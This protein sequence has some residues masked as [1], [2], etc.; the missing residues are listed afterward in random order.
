MKDNPDARAAG[1]RVVQEARGRRSR[2]ARA[3][4][5]VPRR[6]VGRVRG[7][8]RPARHRVR[9]GPRRERVRARHG[10]RDRGAA[11]RADHRE[12]GRAGRR[13]RGREDAD[14][15][16]RPRTAPRCTRRA[17]S[18]R[19]STAGR[20]TT[21]RARSTS[22]IAARRCTSASCSSCSRRPATTGPRAA[23]T[24]RTGWSA[25]GGKKTGTRARQRRAHAATCSTIAA[26]RG[27]RRRSPSATR[28]CP[29]SVVDDVAQQVGIGAVVFANLASQREK[30]V[31]FDLEKAIS[32]DGRLRALPPVQPR[33]L[34]LDPAQGRRAR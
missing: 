9:R 20:P 23:S 30:D 17:T 5:A 32:L 27:P 29:P 25:L 3:V 26:G 34:R 31:D 28:A 1:P 14:P 19:R 15:A 2:G 24:S 12:R 18:P 4:A 13:A 10:R 22:S 11:R 6:V 16:A 21:S 7:G 33:P 8:L